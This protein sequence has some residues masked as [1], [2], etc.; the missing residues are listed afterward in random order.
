MQKAE[1]VGDRGVRF[2]LAGSDDRE[3]PLILGLM[4]VLPKHAINPETFEQTSLT[5]PIGSG[6]YVVAHVDPGKS[7]TLK[8]NPDY[9]GRDLG[10]NRGLWNF[11][12]IHFDYYRDAN[13][14]HEAFKRGLFDVRTETDPGR[15]QTAYDF[16]ALREGR[17][18]KEAFTTG[19]PKP[20]TYLVFNTRR[21]MFSDVRV[22]E[23]LLLLFDFEWINHSYFFDLYRRTGS[24]FEGSELSSRG[25]P[26][27]ARERALLAPFPDAVRAD[28]LDGTWSAA[29]HRRLGARPQRRCAARSTC[30]RQAGYELRGTELVE[31]KHRPAVHLRDH[32]RRPGGRAARAA[33]QPEPEARRHQGAGARR[34]RGAVRGAPDRLR[35]RHDPESLGPVAVARATNSPSTGA[36]PPPISTAAA[37]TWASRA[38][39]STR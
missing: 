37:T 15:W 34:R 36:A 30:S 25:R 23:A 4:P 38:P 20:S 13:T 26:A 19:L 10:V 39:P 29:G 7:V 3:L 32:G 27:D 18:V 31:R 2:D 24:F 16:P 21:A 33:V 5:P 12:E 17:V 1:V 9:W 11:D 35:L 14:F 28:V 6:P 8:R 22:R